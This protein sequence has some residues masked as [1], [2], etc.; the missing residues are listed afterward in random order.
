MRRAIGV[1][2]KS[3]QPGRTKTRLAGRLGNDGAARL[4]QQLMTLALQRACSLPE[5]SVV[6]W[7]DGEMDHAFVLQCAREFA[8]AVE[9]QRGKDLGIRMHNAFAVMLEQNDRALIVGTDCPAQQPSDLAAAFV[10][11]DNADAVVQPAEDGG[12]VLIGLSRLQPALF[13]DVPWGS[14]RVLAVTRERAADA[15]IALAELPAS[16]DLDRPAD[17]DRALALGLIAEP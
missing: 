6:L 12:Y 13:I 10:A 16:W 8:V 17:Y 5:A 15:G 2:A 14:E 7:I 4:Q 1:F 11:L 9:P 3:P